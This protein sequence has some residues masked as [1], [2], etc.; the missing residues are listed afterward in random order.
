MTLLLREPLYLLGSIFAVLFAANI[1]GH[2]LAMATG[3]NGDS[4]LRLHIEGLRQGLFFLLGL[5]LGFTVAMVLP[6]FDQ[7]RGLVSDE[8][9]AID[10]TW[11]RAETLPEPQRDRT[12][13]LLREYAVVRRDFAHQKLA[14][15][16]DLNRHIQQTKALQ[17]QLWQQ[18]VPVAVQNQTSITAAYMQA[19]NEMIGVS[20][21][22]L[23]AFENRV[24]TEVWSII[25]LV[26]IFQSFITGYSL[27]RKIW[28]TLIGIPLVVAAVMALIADLDD[29]H[30]GN[31]R[32]EQSS[33]NRL[34]NDISQR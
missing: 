28:L 17:D 26:A 25:L 24:P 30:S 21:K 14:D 33:M 16:Q 2:R 11:L 31:I 6:K 12:F 18:I 10:T 29:P 8:A 3:I 13:Q 5:L 4:E 19:L 23:T 32:I 1:C 20:E 34:I 15:Q 9:H 7:R 22:R 27:K